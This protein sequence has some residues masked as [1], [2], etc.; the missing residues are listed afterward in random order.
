MSAGGPPRPPA[1]PSAA[2]TPPAGGEGAAVSGGLAAEQPAPPG[3]DIFRALLS[4]LIGVCTVIPLGT[5][6]YLKVELAKIELINKSICRSVEQVAQQNFQITCAG[7]GGRYDF[8]SR[9]CT[10]TIGPPARFEF[11]NP[12]EPAA[13]TRSLP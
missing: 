4:A 3:R 6:L 8:N 11:R 13:A 5:L 12:C 1:P 9:V 2:E 7:L 10:S